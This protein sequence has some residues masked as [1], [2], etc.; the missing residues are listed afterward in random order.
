MD[1]PPLRAVRRRVLGPDGPDGP[2]G[3]GV[4]L[5]LS[6][7]VNGPSRPPRRG[8]RPPLRRRARAA[9]ARPPRAGPASRAAVSFGAVAAPPLSLVTRTSMRCRRSSSRSPSSVKGPRS[10][11]ISIRAGRGAVGRVHGPHQEPQFV[12]VREGG[13]PHPSG[14]QEDPPH[15]P[16]SAG[17]A[18]PRRPPPASRQ[19]ASRRP[20][21]EPSRAG[22][23][24]AGEHGRWRRPAPRGN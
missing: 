7:V 9:C 24:P 11:S 13:K 12:E 18:A 3:P 23:A 20:R 21:R 10:S 5:S 15:L 17:E 2:G 19:S 16:P 22:A 8:P 4:V 1:A 14:G 6:R